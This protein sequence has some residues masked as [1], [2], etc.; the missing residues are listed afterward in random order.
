M[1][2]NLHL[3]PSTPGTTEKVRENGPV[4]RIQGQLARHGRY[5]YAHS[6]SSVGFAA[7]VLQIM[8]SLGNFAG[9]LL[10]VLH[11]AV[12]C[13]P[14]LVPTHTLP[15]TNCPSES[16]ELGYPSDMR[17]HFTANVDMP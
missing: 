9:L 17:F 16:P 12:H 14:F 11:I 15:S 3:K 2:T 10:D 4:L 6:C 1:H 13:L 5:R 7:Y 8:V